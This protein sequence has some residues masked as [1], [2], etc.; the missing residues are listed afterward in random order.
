MLGSK[1]GISL[2]ALLVSWLVAGCGGGSPVPPSAPKG[3]E[4]V[5]GPAGGGAPSAQ[6][7]ST[8]GATAAAQPTVACTYGDAKDCRAKCD[9]GN[10]Q[11]CGYLSTMLI[12]G[13]SLTQDWPAGCALAAKACD[14]NDAVGCNNSGACF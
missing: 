13:V 2:A 6:P 5:A 3:P 1:C 4:P 7:S 12:G 14:A 8:P 11:S 9:A 10:T